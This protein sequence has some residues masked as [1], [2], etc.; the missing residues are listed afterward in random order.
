M[1]VEYDAEGYYVLYP[2][3][4]M[5]MAFGPIIPNADGES[6]REAHAYID[7]AGTGFLAEVRY[8]FKDNNV[9]HSALYLADVGYEKMDLPVSHDGLVNLR[10]VEMLSVPMSI[11]CQIL[12]ASLDGNVDTETASRIES[13]YRMKIPLED[14]YLKLLNDNGVFGTFTE[15]RGFTVNTSM[16][17][18]SLHELFI[19]LDKW[20]IDNKYTEEPGMSM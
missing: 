4:Q 2:K 15:A 7:E 8:L 18:H 17:K 12:R 10:K 16:P 20:T 5:V 14:K 3:D 13:L 1:I 11:Q 9:I 19:H 6:L